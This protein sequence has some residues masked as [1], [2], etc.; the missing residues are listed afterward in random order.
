MRKVVV[1]YK[2]AMDNYREE[3]CTGPYVGTYAS[4]VMRNLKLMGCQD[5][6]VEPYVGPDNA[7]KGFKERKA[8]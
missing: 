3:Y 5:F 1:Y 6:R 4:D 2:D 8:A 7:V